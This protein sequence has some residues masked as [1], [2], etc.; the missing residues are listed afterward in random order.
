MNI[1]LTFSTKSDS[2]ITAVLSGAAFLLLFDEPE[3]GSVELTSAAPVWVGD[4]A[5]P[6][7]AKASQF[8]TASGSQPFLYQVDKYQEK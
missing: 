8:T 3:E 7:P 2:V 4:V 1:T 5:E 6:Q